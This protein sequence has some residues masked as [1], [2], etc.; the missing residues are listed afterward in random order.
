MTIG[1][2]L[3]D[4]LDRA[5]GVQQAVLNIGE[6]MRSLGHN[7]HY[8]VTETTRTDIQNVHSLTCV[9]NFKFNGNSV[10]TPM[11]ASRDAIRKLFEEVSFDVLHIQMPFSPLFGARVLAAAPS[12]V[13]TVG[14]FHIL[15]YNMFAA[16]GTKLLGLSQRKMVAA[17]DVRYAVSEPAR[18]FMQKTYGCEAEVL[19][20]PVAWKFFNRYQTLH[21]AEKRVVFVGRFEERKGVREL[22]IAFSKLPESL[23]KSTRLILCGKGPL[24]DSVKHLALTLDVHVE[25]PG[26]VTEEQKAEY[27]A[28]ATV[29][30]FPSLRGESF[31]IVLVEAMSAGARVTLGGN[32]PGYSSVLAPWPEVLFDPVDSHVFTAAL[33]RFLTDDTLALHIGDQQRLAAKQYDISVVA[34]RLL[35]EAYQITTS[36][37]KVGEETN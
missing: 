1:Y 18:V 23:R 31:G 34:T 28:G 22:I 36:T 24:M 7:V 11:P 20:N 21:F 16:V 26:F 15:P 32:N 27:L 37:Q 3:D 12:S 8:L 33:E 25:L 30:V 13:R 35:Q 5:D 17:L 10:R 4:S 29:A 19:P 2:I 14:T 6:Y 9:R